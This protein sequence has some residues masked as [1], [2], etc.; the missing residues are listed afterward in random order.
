MV[1]ILSENLWSIRFP[2]YD[3]ITL[4]NPIAVPRNTISIV[5][6]W[7]NVSTPSFGR[8][9]KAVANAKVPI[10]ACLVNP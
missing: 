8:L 4:M 7:L 1:N 9:S 10:R 5:M 6:Y 2:T 3:A